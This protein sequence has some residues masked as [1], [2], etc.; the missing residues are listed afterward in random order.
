MTA[1]A[2]ELAPNGAEALA[3]ACSTYQSQSIFGKHGL[4]MMIVCGSSL[5]KPIISITAIIVISTNCIRLLS[6]A[7]RNKLFYRHGIPR[8]NIQNF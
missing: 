4:V 6:P 3:A 2:G 1:V 7:H 5:S 8:E